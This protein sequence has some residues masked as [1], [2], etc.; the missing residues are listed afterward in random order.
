VP[1]GYVFSIWGLIYI[2]LI[3]FSIYQAL[4]AQRENPRLVRLG[5][6]PALTGVANT[7]WIFL[8]HYEQFPLT[9]VAMLA[10]LVTLIAIYLQLRAG[11]PQVSRAE[12]WMVFLPFSVYLGW[13][14]V[15]TIANIS[16]VLYAA[17]W[18]GWGI[19][20]P[21][22]AALLLLVA[23]G[24]GLVMY[25]TRK[26]AAYVLVLVWAFIGIAV[27][28]PETPVVFLTAWVASMVLVVALASGLFIRRGS[29]RPVMA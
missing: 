21:L 20:A 5:Y 18:S 28:F 4:P 13:I 24:L 16:Q 10:L 3:L 25:F 17:G 27:K 19:S 23:T 9:L 6:L 22:W 2:G 11:R 14:S 8:W 7:A 15:A 1:A 26:D 12:R 29:S